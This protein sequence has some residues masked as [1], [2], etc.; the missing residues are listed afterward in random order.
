MA[1]PSDLIQSGTFASRPAAS[2]AGLL[3]YATDTKRTYRD[4]GSSWDLIANARGE[5]VALASGMNPTTTSGCAARTT[6]EYATNDVDLQLLDFDQTTDEYAHF[7]RWVPDDYDGGTLTFKVMWTAASGSGDV[8]WGLQGRAYTNDDALDQSWG[9][10][11]TVTDTLIT[12]N[13]VHI[14]PESSALTLAG[15]PD[16]GYLLKFRIYRDADAGSDTL[17]A[18]ARLI[19]LKIYYTKD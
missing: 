1:V 3:Y 2:V 13:D 19:G 7:T 11:Q 4:N 9:T 10:A 18:D 6:V 8:V 14:S 5:I 16:G 15:S 12:A 17:N